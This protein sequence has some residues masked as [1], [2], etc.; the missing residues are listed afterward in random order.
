MK[1]YPVQTLILDCRALGFGG[2]GFRAQHVRWI[3]GLR[4]EVMR[5]NKNPRP[6]TVK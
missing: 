1:L 5:L 3:V 2:L 6:S 4:Q